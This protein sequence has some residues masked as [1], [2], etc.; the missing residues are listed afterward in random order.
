MASLPGDPSAIA[1]L[2]EPERSRLPRP[3]WLA[4]VLAGFLLVSV[5]AIMVPER[6]DSSIALASLLVLV[7]LYVMATDVS[8]LLSLYR[9]GATEEI[10]LAGFEPDRLAEAVA[11]HSARSTLKVGFPLAAGVLPGAWLMGPK[12]LLLLLL[13]VPV[14]FMAVAAGVCLL[15]IMLPLAA[16]SHRLAAAPSRSRRLPLVG[17]P[18]LYRELTRWVAG[19]DRSFR[20]PGGP[21]A[22]VLIAGAWGWDR[23]DDPRTPGDLDVPFLLA[24][25]LGFGLGALRAVASATSERERRTADLLACT[26]MSPGEILFG[27]AAAA[28][29]PAACEMGLAVAVLLGMESLRIHTVVDG[30]GVPLPLVVLLSIAPAAGALLGLEAAQA[31]DRREAAARLLGL[32]L[33]L[34]VASGVWLGVMA[35]AV[36]SG[37]PEGPGMLAT[38][39]LLGFGTRPVSRLHGRGALLVLTAATAAVATTGVAPLARLIWH[40]GT[41]LLLACAYSFVLMLP[42]LALLQI[43]LGGLLDAA[44]SG[45]TLRRL[46]GGGAGGA[47]AGLVASYAVPLWALRSLYEYGYDPH[48]FDPLKCWSGLSALA[49][50]AAVGALAGWLGP[51]PAPNPRG[52]VLRAAALALVVGLLAAGF[53][54]DSP[55]PPEPDPL[56]Q[57]TARHARRVRETRGRLDVAALD[58]DHAPPRVVVER[59]ERVLQGDYDLGPVPSLGQKNGLPLAKVDALLLDLAERA[60]PDSAA[61]LHLLR[62]HLGTRVLGSGPTEDGSHGYRLW[63]EGARQFSS[64]LPSVSEGRLRQFLPAPRDP[65]PLLERSLDAWASRARFNTESVRNLTSPVAQLPEPFLRWVLDRDRALLSAAFPRL[66]AQAQRELNPEFRGTLQVDPADPAVVRVWS[67]ESQKLVEVYR[68][69]DTWLEAHRI[70]AALE[71]HRREHGRYPAS[72]DALSKWLTPP[73]VAHTSANG[74]FQFVAGAK[75]YRL[76]AEGVL[77]EVP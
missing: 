8:R 28:A 45:G 70:M 62:L 47:L 52:A 75:G 15:G 53:W 58:L 1:I 3:N 27:R 36:W 5:P 4:C 25:A 41:L 22:V 65:S 30:A 6:L 7:P 55:T 50:G 63:E 34:A 49:V 40:D 37:A 33:Q 44:L 17:N 76:S 31:P 48:R 20:I 13:W 51:A 68:R 57:A 11:W 9:G 67:R 16:R 23:L 72:L 2:L 46:L 26:P 74:R 56:E 42:G 71:L 32:T 64:L 39:V 12:W 19:G 60:A 73:P 77:L 29:L 66:V 43:G 61:D 69:H 18:L 54:V 59:L 21:L 14:S 10:R 35:V 24:A 38:A